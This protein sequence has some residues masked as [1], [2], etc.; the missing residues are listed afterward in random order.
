[1][2]TKVSLS[3]SQKF[4]FFSAQNKQIRLVLDFYEEVKTSTNYQKSLENYFNKLCE[5]FQFPA[6]FKPKLDIPAE[7]KDIDSTRTNLE[8]AFKRN[9]KILFYVFK[10]K[11]CVLGI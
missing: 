1:M 11:N 9:K 8:S 4:K 5:L 2:E 6:D 7:I 10:I 3:F